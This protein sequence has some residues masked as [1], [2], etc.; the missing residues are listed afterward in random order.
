MRLPFFLCTIALSL[1]LAAEFDVEQERTVANNPPGL[2]LSLRFA[3]GKSVFRQ[4]EP[5]RVFTARDLIFQSD[6]TNG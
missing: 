3:D 1:S 2:S 4:G 6:G 5:I